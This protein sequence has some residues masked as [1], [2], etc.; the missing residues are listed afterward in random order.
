MASIKKR[1]N[2]K[3]TVVTADAQVISIKSVRLISH[4]KDTLDQRDSRTDKT[5]R[6]K[7]ENVCIEC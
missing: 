7:L 5:E 2:K 1:T 3:K 6:K 4:M